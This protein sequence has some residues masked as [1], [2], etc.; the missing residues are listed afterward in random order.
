MFWLYVLLVLALLTGAY[1]YLR[2]RGF[3]SDRLGSGADVGPG[4]EHASH[5]RPDSLSGG[6]GGGG[7]GI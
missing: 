5:F 6:G 7:S 4:R 3:F 1:Y 2:H